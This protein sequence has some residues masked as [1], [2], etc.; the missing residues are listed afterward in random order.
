MQTEYLKSLLL[1]KAEKEQSIFIESL[2]SQPPEKIIEAAYE[3][4]IR[5]DLLLT[6]SLIHIF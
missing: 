3:K 1:N 6:L 2:K 4:V 5:D